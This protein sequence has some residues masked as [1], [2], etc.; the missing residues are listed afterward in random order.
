MTDFRVRI[1]GNAIKGRY[2][3]H[4]EREGK[5]TPISGRSSEPLLASCRQLMAI[6]PDITAA[7]NASLYWPHSETP[8]LTVGVLRGAGLTVDESGPRFVKFKQFPHTGQ[9]SSTAM[10]P[11]ASG[12]LEKAKAQA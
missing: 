9:T 4:V 1:T 6:Y 8:S 2:P 7:D 11:L 10:I 12:Q 3:Y 5:L